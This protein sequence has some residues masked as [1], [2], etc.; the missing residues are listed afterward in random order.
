MGLGKRDWPKPA[1][2]S[3]SS[4]SPI[5][6]SEASPG[7]RRKEL[8]VRRTMLEEGREGKSPEQESRFDS[9]KK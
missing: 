5:T 1:P 2:F 4:K 3:A 8:V 7:D 9:E 6:R